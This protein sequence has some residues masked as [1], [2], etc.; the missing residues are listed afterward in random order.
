[1][2]PKWGSPTAPAPVT[3]QHGHCPPSR[4]AWSKKDTQLCLTHWAL[5]EHQEG[6]AAVRHGDGGETKV[7]K[8][9]WAQVPRQLLLC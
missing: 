9:M 4:R 2:I 3:H 6:R 8:R 7:K 1:M 5:K